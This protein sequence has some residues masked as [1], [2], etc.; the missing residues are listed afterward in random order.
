MQDL[1]V[2]EHRL[3]RQHIVLHGAVAHRVGAGRARRRH[4]AERSIGARID[5]EEQALVAQIFV[6]L[7]AGHARLDHAVEI[8]GMNVEHAV[9]VLEIDGDAAERRVE[10]AFERGPRAVGNDRD[11]VLGAQPHDRLHV[12]G[13]LREHHRVGG[14]VLEPGR[15]VRVLL[16]DRERSHQPVAELRRERLDRRGNRPRTGSLARCRNCLRRRLHGGFS[17]AAASLS[18]TARGR[19]S[20]DRQRP[21]RRALPMRWRTLRKLPEKWLPEPCST[22]STLN[23]CSSRR[24]SPR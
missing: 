9:H 1:A 2:G 19:Q 13:A 15:G 21:T 23:R 24:S 22:A 6:E 4:A 12:R 5:R 7:L 14:L 8:A 11:P 18:E 20:R 10:V 3:E 17:I 16:A